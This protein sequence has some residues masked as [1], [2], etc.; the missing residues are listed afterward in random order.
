MHANILVSR[1]QQ[2]L[3]L[4]RILAIFVGSLATLA[5]QRDNDAA[6]KTP[7]IHSVCDISQEFTFY[8]DG[9]FFTQ[10]LQGIA[11]DVRNW[12]SLHRLDLHNVNLLVLA[13]GD[14][15]IPYSEASI[16]H[17]AKYVEGGGTLLVM[18]RRGEPK[19]PVDALL[20]LFGASIGRE[21]C[22]PPLR[23]EG[24][25]TAAQI[26]GRPSTCFECDD[27][28]T[29]LI[30]A[31]RANTRRDAKPG[32]A[33]DA[34]TRLPL[35]ALRDYGKGHVLIGARGL[36][37]QRPDA[38]D[39]INKAWLSPLLESLATTKT[40]D[41]DEPHRSTWAE[42]EKKLGALTLEYHDGTEPFAR[43][44]AEEYET[45]FPHLV[46]ITG[47]EPARGMLKRLLILP[48]GGGG[49]SSGNRIAIGAFWGNYP[50]KRYPMVEL[51]GHEAGHSWV[52]PYPEPLW[53]EPIATYLGIQVGKR[54]GMNEADQTLERQIAKARKLD[55]DLNKI[56]PL[57]KDAPRDLVWGKSYYVFEELE[58]RFGP[59]AMAKYFRTKRTVLERGRKGYSMDDCVAVWSR[60]VG[61]DLFPWFRS[62]AFG[63]DASKTDVR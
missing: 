42:H 62:L 18:A 57:A 3:V 10:Y 46:A 59:G 39:D 24:R 7:R 29:S 23:G 38:N 11:K 52:L 47:V 14:R 41:P 35:L 28:W 12:G 54:L 19:P 15:R 21:A 5:A 25:L 31:K 13:D 22:K 58:R 27:T 20:S 9:R 60:A 17:I 1:V 61:E 55:P 30:V 37:G 32:T 43:R 50:E 4:A 63:V 49:F 26:Q 16:L 8:M 44:I 48:T 2:R 56:D 34:T 40:I 53:N 36:F 33:D 6:R 45:V 51:I